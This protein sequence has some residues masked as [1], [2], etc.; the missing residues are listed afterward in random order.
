MD[1]QKDLLYVEKLK[2]EYSFDPKEKSKLEELKALDLKVKKPATIFAYTFGI[3]GSL[4]LGVG[5]CLAMK[6]IGSTTGLMIL[7][8]V[9]GFLGILM[10]TTNYPVYKNIIKSRKQKH[11]KEILNLSNELLNNN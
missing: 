2:K 8:I 10:I 9:I 7:G 3:L 5:M 4:I 1:N 11:S 6:I